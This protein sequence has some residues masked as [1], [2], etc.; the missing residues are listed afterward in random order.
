[1]NSQAFGRRNIMASIDEKAVHVS[2]L[3]NPASQTEEAKQ[4]MKSAAKFGRK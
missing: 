2:A 3:L 1:M 4:A